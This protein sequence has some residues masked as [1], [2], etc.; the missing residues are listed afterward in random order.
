MNI[1]WKDALGALRDSGAIPVDNTPDP[2]EDNDSGN[3]IQKTPLK[4]IIDRK[5]RKGKT[6]TIIEGFTG[7][8]EQLEDLAKTL[9]Q[10]LG[11]GGSARGGE[12]LIQGERKNDVITILR[13]LGYKAN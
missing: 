3:G 4:V 12:I 7:S 8:D 6:A 9:K 10:K 11:T 5:G 1:D 2:I 13:S